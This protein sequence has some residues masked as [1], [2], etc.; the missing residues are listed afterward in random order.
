MNKKMTAKIVK[1]VLL[2]LAAFASA[3]LIWL[4]AQYHREVPGAAPALASLIFRG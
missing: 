4:L 1:T 3:V 2:A